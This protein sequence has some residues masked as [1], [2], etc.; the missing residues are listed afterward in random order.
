MVSAFAEA[1]IVE[2]PSWAANAERALAFAREHLWDAENG[3]L[4]RRFRDGDVAIEGYLEDYAF[5]ARG[6]VDTYAATGDLEHLTFALEL[7]NVVESE[8][9]DGDDR[10][11]YFT[12]RSGESLVARPQELADQSTPS[13]AGV[14]AQLLA[15]LDHFVDHDRYGEVAKGVVETHASRVESDPLQHPSLVLAADTLAAGASELT[16]AGDLPA[17]WRERLGETYV[18]RRLLAPRPADDDA[19]GDWLDR[20]GLEEAP[21]IWA[22]RAARDG[23]PT[24][25]ACQSRTCSPPTHD[26]AEALEWFA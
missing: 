15:G 11:L 18:P 24:L 4:S 13:S 17:T 19:L 7:A 8:F 5:L 22:G 2:D 26:I 3:R 1:A 16:V 14:A 6:A 21:P 12:P 23:D 10:T 9:W 20:L 25:Y